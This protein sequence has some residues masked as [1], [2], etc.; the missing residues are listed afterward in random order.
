MAKNCESCS[1]PLLSDFKGPSD[2]YCVYCTDEKGNLKPPQ[3]VQKGIAKWVK[4]WQEGI[5]DEQAI[6]RAGYFMKAMP[7]WAEESVMQK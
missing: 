1:A 3:E 2:R 7:A 6:T 5:S 4:S